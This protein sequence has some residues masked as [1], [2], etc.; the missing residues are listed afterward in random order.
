[1]HFEIRYRI[2]ICLYLGSQISYRKVFVL[3]TKLWISPFQWIMSQPSIMFL[4]REI[5]QNLWCEFSE[6]FFVP[7]FNICMEIVHQMFWPNYL[8]NIYQKFLKFKNLIFQKFLN[9]IFLSD[10][11][12]KIGF[13]SLNLAFFQTNMPFL[14]Q[15]VLGL[16]V[17]TTIL[18]TAMV[19]GVP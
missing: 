10:P 15:N 13:I 19:Q 3:Q 17:V 14:M 18:S 11:I 16:Q 7:P 8:Y 5:E 2:L 6:V 4:V 9:Y 1:M 12:L